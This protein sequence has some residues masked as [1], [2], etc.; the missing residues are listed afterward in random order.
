MHDHSASV[1]TDLIDWH[2]PREQT[3]SL[4]MRRV[5]AGSLLIILLAPWLVALTG[6]AVPLVPCPMHRGSAATILARTDAITHDHHERA[7]HSSG[8]HHGTTARGCNC[9]GECG[10]LGGAFALSS[11]AAR[12]EAINAGSASFVPEDLSVGTWAERFYPPS[13]GPPSRLRS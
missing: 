11:I 10:Q 1:G 5:F 13:T 8:S 12:P 9:A 3:N 6:T 2:S 7:N 4:V